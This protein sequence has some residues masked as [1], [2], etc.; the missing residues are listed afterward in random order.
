MH[1]MD[2][3]IFADVRFSWEGWLSCRPTND[4]GPHNKEKNGTA[5]RPSLPKLN[6]FLAKCVVEARPHR[7]ED[8]HKVAAFRRRLFP[9]FLP[10]LQ[11]DLD[12]LF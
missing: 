8:E 5:Q 6:Q 7:T 4:F 11:Q 9:L 12:S 2:L 1:R 10:W 3:V